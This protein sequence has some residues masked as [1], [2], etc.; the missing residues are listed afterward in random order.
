MVSDPCYDDDEHRE[1]KAQPTLEEMAERVGLMRWDNWVKSATNY[2]GR[3]F[4][5]QVGREEWKRGYLINKYYEWK[6]GR[7]A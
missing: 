4:Q 3:L 6:N 1:L 7:E 2:A 5:D